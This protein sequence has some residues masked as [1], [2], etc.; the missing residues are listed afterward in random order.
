MHECLPKEVDAFGSD[1]FDGSGLGILQNRSYRID[2]EVLIGF[3][4]V[5]AFFI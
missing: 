4:T 1:R 3:I 2:R 5:Q